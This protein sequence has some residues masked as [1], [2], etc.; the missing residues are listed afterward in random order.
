MGQSD[1]TRDSFWPAS[2]P[3]HLSPLA[4]AT[5]SPAINTNSR[6]AEDLSAP[7]LGPVAYLCATYPTYPKSLTSH[8]NRLSRERER[9]GGH[10]WL[11]GGGGAKVQNISRANPFLLFVGRVGG[12]GEGRRTYTYTPPPPTTTKLRPEEIKLEGEKEKKKA[13]LC[14]YWC[15]K[16]RGGGR[17]SCTFSTSSGRLFASGPL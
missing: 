10:V 3:D 12:G 9:R 7:P 6:T 11:G 16:G 15:K 17:G 8:Q 4:P 14:R 13:L 2:E 5:L 1:L